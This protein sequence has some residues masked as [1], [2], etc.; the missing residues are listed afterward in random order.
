[1]LIQENYAAAAEVF[2]IQLNAVCKRICRCLCE[3]Y[4]FRPSVKRVSRTVVLYTTLVTFCRD[5]S[6]EEEDG[7]MVYL[8]QV[9][10]QGCSHTKVRAAIREIK[11]QDSL[12][13]KLDAL[14]REVKQSVI[15]TQNSLCFN[16]GVIEN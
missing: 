3:M 6:L 4:E 16:F 7:L 11:A 1:M 15:L 12:L 5:F 8:E 14:L 10:N 2:N 13:S 9:L